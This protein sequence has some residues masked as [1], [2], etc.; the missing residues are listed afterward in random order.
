M[1]SAE[2]SITVARPISEVFAYVADIERLPEWVP[3]IQ[4][5]EPTS[6]DMNQVG[7][8]YVVTARFMGRTMQ[9]P[10][11]IV[12]YEPNRLYAYRAYGSMAYQDTM[13]FDQTEQGT[14]IK[15][16]IV[17]ASTGRLARLVDSLKIMVSKSSHKKNLQLLK[18]ILETPR[19]AV[20]A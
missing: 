2:L 8:T 17:M 7:A 4:R 6:A 1:L 10:S 14:L 18:Q 11:E 19:T 9:I 12:G 16:H 5:A 15:E 3:V 13:V 20:A